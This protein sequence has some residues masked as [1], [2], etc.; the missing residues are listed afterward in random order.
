M[1]GMDSGK[2]FDCNVIDWSN[3]VSIKVICFDRLSIKW[4][5]SKKKV[6]INILSSLYF[7]FRIIELFC[8]SSIARQQ[9][10]FGLYHVVVLLIDVVLII[11]LQQS[12]LLLLPFQNFF[13]LLRLVLQQS[14][15]LFFVK[16]FL[17]EYF[18]PGL[19]CFVGRFF[20]SRM[21]K[22]VLVD[23]SGCFWTLLL[24]FWWLV[25]FFW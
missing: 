16:F 10:E 18:S 19:I 6:K 20:R 17:C 25:S 15:L 8:R 3:S 4:K 24:K 22:V 21:G 14:C 13:N 5:I 11:F 23:R 12:T 1:F 7:Q 9:A 2:N